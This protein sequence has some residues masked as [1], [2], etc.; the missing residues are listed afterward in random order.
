[1]ANVRKIENHRPSFIFLPNT[2][3]FPDGIRLIPGM[4]SVPEKYMTELFDFEIVRFKTDVVK[5]DKDGNR[6]GGTQAFPGRETLEQLQQ[7]VR[8]LRYEGN[9]TS[10]QITVYP[11]GAVLDV[12][13]GPRLPHDLGEY[14]PAP[15]LTLIRVISDKEALK[16]WTKDPRK[17]I[18]S[19]A[20]TRISSLNGL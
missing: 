16:R 12:E 14:E 13:D 2:E 10:P 1:M 5:R 17:E 8:I 4:N 15:A 20:Q 3:S 11:E 18:A 7:P 19:A 9:T 6:V